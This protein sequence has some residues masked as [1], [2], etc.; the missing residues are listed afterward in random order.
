[1]YKKIT[2]IIVLAVALAAFLVLRPYIFK[3]EAPPRIVDRLPEADF[4]ARAYLLDVARETSGMLYYHK[5][6]FRD[7][8]SQEFILSQSKLYGLNL[9]QPS[10]IFANEEGD[11]GTI[12]EVSDS[13]KILQGIERLRKVTAIKDTVIYDKK[14]YQILEQDG[15]LVYD[16]SYMFLYKGNEFAKILKRVTKCKHG[17]ISPVWKSFLREKQF[18]DEKLVIYSNWEKLKE[19]GIETAIFAHNSDSVSFSLLSYIRNKKPLNVSMKQE[20]RNLLS[21]GYTSKML[22]I[23]L[24]VTQ[25]RKNPEDP[26]YKLLVKLGKKISFPTVEFLNAWEGD[27]SFRQGGFQLVKE[28]YIE[29]ELDENFNVTE[30]EKEKEVKV[31]GFSLLVSLNNNGPRFIQTLLAKG[32]LTFEEDKY[33]MLF[34]P[35]LHMKKIKNYYVFHNGQSTPKQENHGKNNGVWTQRGTRFEF[36][37]DSLSKYEAFGSIYIPVNRIISRNRFF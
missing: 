32:I 13:S 33:R 25:L 31:P 14:V 21:G 4:V 28:T 18:K 7:F 2:L 1:M 20:G 11:W 24:D 5:V 10:Y 22:N 16:K 29:S 6:P 19:N 37:L 23:H 35:P 9:Q 12:I 3:K 27:L 17:D 8:F 15:Y 36:S 30:V 26:L 34:S